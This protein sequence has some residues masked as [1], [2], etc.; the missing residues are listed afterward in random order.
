MAWIYYPKV[1]IALFPA[2]F[3]CHLSLKI[4]LCYALD[5]MKMEFSF[6]QRSMGFVT[7]YSWGSQS[8]QDRRRQGKIDLNSQTSKLEAKS[9]QRARNECCHLLLLSHDFLQSCFPHFFLLLSIPPLLP[10]FSF[11]I[12]FL[13]LFSVKHA[14]RSVSLSLSQCSPQ[15]CQLGKPRMT[16][17]K[18]GKMAHQSTHCLYHV[19]CGCI[20]EGWS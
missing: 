2:S 16:W 9:L 17:K 7:N 15:H 19:V 10:S 20:F 3:H 14:L 6:T 11:P 5:L 13:L 12:P 8:I 1:T 4:L 18:K